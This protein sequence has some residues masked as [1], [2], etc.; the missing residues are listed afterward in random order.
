[1]RDF[2]VGLLAGLL[3]VVLFAAAAAVLWVII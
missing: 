2:A 1:M 3:T